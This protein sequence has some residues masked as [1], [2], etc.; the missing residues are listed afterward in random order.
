[1]PVYQIQAI[2]SLKATPPHVPQRRRH[3]LTLA[4][5]KHQFHRWSPLNTYKHIK[6]RCLRCP[7]MTA[8]MAVL[9]NERRR[10]LR[11]AGV[12]AW[13]LCAYGGGGWC[14]DGGEGDHATRRAIITQVCAWVGGSKPVAATAA[15]PPL[16]HPGPPLAKTT[17]SLGFCIGWGGLRGRMKWRLRIKR[18]LERT[19][20]FT[21]ETTSWVCGRPCSRTHLSLGARSQRRRDAVRREKKCFCWGGDGRVQTKCSKRTYQD[22]FKS[23]KNLERKQRRRDVFVNSSWYC[24]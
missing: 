23:R 9:R 24:E 4:R 21:Q 18:I 20:S 5:Q 8:F 7:S 10:A 17:K 19:T 14:W 11:V 15:V 16:R 2:K 12:E 1:M 22:F 3:C 6:H 13:A